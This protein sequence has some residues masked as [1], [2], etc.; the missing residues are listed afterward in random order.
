MWPDG[1]LLGWRMK[2][3]GVFLPNDG[4]ENALICG[5]GSITIAQLEGTVTHCPFSHLAIILHLA[6]WHLRL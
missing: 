4:G 6:M 2:G 3:F 5:F 1:R